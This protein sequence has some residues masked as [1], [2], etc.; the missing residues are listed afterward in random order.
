MRRCCAA[1]TSGHHACVAIRPRLGLDQP[2]ESAVL[3][4]E[5]IANNNGVVIR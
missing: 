3:V 1:S 5:K 4:Q 2:D